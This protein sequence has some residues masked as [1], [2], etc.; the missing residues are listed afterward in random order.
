MGGGA[1]QCSGAVG[2]SCRRRSDRSLVQGPAQVRV[3][4][5][6]RRSR[7][8]GVRSPPDTLSARFAACI[9]QLTLAL[10]KRR[11]ACRR[12]PET[13]VHRPGRKHRA[14]WLLRLPPTVALDRT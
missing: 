3:V 14:S 12:E 6:P 9:A 4:G 7:D 13:L 2:S 10:P 1:V 8:L 11:E 5:R